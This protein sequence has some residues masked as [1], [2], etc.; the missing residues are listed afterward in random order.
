MCGSCGEICFF[1]LHATLVIKN[2]QDRKLTITANEND[3][4]RI[5]SI[6]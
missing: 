3:D 4:I 1:D 2:T 5:V 6:M